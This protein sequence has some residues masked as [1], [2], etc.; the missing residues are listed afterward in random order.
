MNAPTAP[1]TT[2]TSGNGQQ[3]HFRKHYLIYFY[4]FLFEDDQ[5][6]RIEAKCEPNAMEHSEAS[7]Q[8]IMGIQQKSEPQLTAQQLQ[9]GTA[10][11]TTV[12]TVASTIESPCGGCR[13][14]KR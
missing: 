9:T 1:L 2:Q 5:Q 14:L 3:G 7:S 11:M 4:F 6:Q 10:Q 13:E 12:A 8:Q